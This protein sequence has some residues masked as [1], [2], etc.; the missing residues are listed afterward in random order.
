MWFARERVRNGEV[1]PSR[2]GKGLK[3]L[4][5]GAFEDVTKEKAILAGE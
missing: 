4:L 5:E 3:L 2:G 1:D